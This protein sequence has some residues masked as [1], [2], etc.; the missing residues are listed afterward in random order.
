MITQVLKIQAREN[1]EAWKQ[2]AQQ[3]EVRFASS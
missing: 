1:I 2:K 3:L